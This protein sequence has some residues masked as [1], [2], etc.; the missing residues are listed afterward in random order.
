MSTFGAMHSAP[1]DL[2]SPA[3]K[4][5][6]LQ[7]QQSESDNLRGSL[8]Q[9]RKDS[10]VRKAA[11]KASLGKWESPEIEPIQEIIRTSP[12]TEEPKKRPTRRSQPAGDAAA[13]AAEEIERTSSSTRSKAHEGSSG[14]ISTS[15][16]G[17]RRRK[18]SQRLSNTSNAS[19]KVRDESDASLQKS[20]PRSSKSTK[21]PSSRKLDNM[22]GDAEGKK[23]KAG[24]SAS[25]ASAPTQLQPN[26]HELSPRVAR[27]GS[28]S[29]KSANSLS[30][31][32]QTRRTKSSDLTAI[33]EPTRKAKRRSKSADPQEHFFDETEDGK[34][35]KSEK[36][37]KSPKKG[38][39]KRPSKKKSGASE[40]S[41]TETST[42]LE[43]EQERSGSRDRRRATSGG[44][45]T[46]PTK[47]AHS[48]GPLKRHNE[49]G[50]DR[51]ERGLPPRAASMM[52]NRDNTRRGKSQSLANLVEYSQDEIHSTSYFASNHVLVNRERMK[53]GLRPLTRNIAMD[54]LARE[55]AKAMADSAGS[56][57]LKTTYVGNVLRGESIRAVH[58]AIMLNR[59]G[60]ERANC[61]NPYFQDFGVGTAK[62]EDG[63][64][65]ICQLFS[66]RLELSC[67]NA[68][69]VEKEKEKEKEKE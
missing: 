40:A 52:L 29:P 46:K 20:K 23:A 24:G 33:A 48:A 44:T 5:L 34:K 21:R 17:G 11:I 59:E 64:L 8:H 10:T 18:G 27:R 67:T 22:L 37:E 54:T 51:P 60:R 49:A 14:T 56:N 12:A 1:I 38:R 6:A 55:S 36:S 7:R 42:E 41:T 58:R 39:K 2:L 35:K 53:R 32:R 57:P 50:A 30:S 28:R 31:K 45:S 25:V 62:G 63:M 43:S 69:D 15:S 19:S 3:K 66:E 26:K 9:R 16:A 61:L 47:R 65:Y 68:V 13:I 4:R